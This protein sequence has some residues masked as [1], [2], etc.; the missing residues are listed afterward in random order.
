MLSLNS[1]LSN[2]CKTALGQPQFSSAEG[3]GQL[4][5]GSIIDILF[6]SLISPL[7]CMAIKESKS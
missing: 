4:E 7:E 3:L 5:M 2:D 1:I 6:D